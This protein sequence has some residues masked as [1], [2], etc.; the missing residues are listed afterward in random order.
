MYIHTS[1]ALDRTI[2][3]G[4]NGVPGACKDSAWP[5]TPGQPRLE[6]DHFTLATSNAGFL[7]VPTMVVSKAPSHKGYHGRT[8]NVGITVATYTKLFSKTHTQLAPVHHFFLK[9]LRISS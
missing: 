9:W 7:L 6:S 2:H 1:I 4:T 3:E 8:C 5:S